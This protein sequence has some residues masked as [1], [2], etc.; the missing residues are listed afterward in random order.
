VPNGLADFLRPFPLGKEGDD[1]CYTELR[2]ASYVLASRA[3]A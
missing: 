2:E 3:M 1:V